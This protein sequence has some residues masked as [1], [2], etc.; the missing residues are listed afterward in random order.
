MT[1]LS[2]LVSRFKSRP[3]DFTWDELASLL[4]KLEF[5][6]AQGSGS[7]VKFYNQ[8]LDCLIQLHKPQPTK[9]IK[10]YVIKEALQLLTN[11]KLL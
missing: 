8:R 3:K 9:I 7:R 11:E 1:K 10:P 4:T 2:K 5:K 6:E